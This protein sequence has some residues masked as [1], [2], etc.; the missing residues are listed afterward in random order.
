MQQHGLLQASQ[1]LVKNQGP[2]V[3]GVVYS[4]LPIGGDQADFRDGAVRSTSVLA[5]K[6]EQVISQAC[7]VISGSAPS[8]NAMENGFDRGLCPFSYQIAGFHDDMRGH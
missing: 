7:L 2:P 8:L 4:R 6:R 3:D 5:G 1:P